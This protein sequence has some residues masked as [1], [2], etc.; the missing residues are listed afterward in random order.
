MSREIIKNEA[1]GRDELVITSSDGHVATLETDDPWNYEIIQIIQDAEDRRNADYAE[2]MENRNKRNEN[3]KRWAK[4]G[5]LAFAAGAAVIGTML[6]MHNAYKGDG[7]IDKKPAPRS[8]AK[9][10][11][12][13]SVYGDHDIWR[14]IKLYERVEHVTTK[15]SWDKVIDANPGVDFTRIPGGE[16][17]KVPGLSEPRDALDAGLETTQPVHD[18]QG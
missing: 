18:T 9:G 12:K 3:R 17:V 5:I 1:T 16:T 2:R 8:Q 13:L 14:Y 7:K 11:F 10:L 6:L 4:K 15:E